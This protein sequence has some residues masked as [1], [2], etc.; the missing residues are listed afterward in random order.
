MLFPRYPHPLPCYT[1]LP[2]PCYTSLPGEGKDTSK[3][4]S[5]DELTA[6]YEN[7]CEKYPVISIEDPFDQVCS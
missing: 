3:L 1:S 2:L 7:F 5:A 4:I 6:I